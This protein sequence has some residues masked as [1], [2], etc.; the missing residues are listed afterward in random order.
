M[1]RKLV[2]ELRAQAEALR[3]FSRESERGS[4]N[5]LLSARQRGHSHALALARQPSPT[6]AAVGK[7]TH[8]PAMLANRYCGRRSMN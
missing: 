5:P 4:L 1:Q 7:Q 8:Q 2:V 6:G 3:P